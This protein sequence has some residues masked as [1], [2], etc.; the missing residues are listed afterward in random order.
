MDS[1]RRWLAVAALVGLTVL[2]Y[3]PSLRA[4]FIWDDDNFLTLNP[5][6][7]ASDGLY[8]FWFTTQATDYW[9]VTSSTLWVEWRLWGMHA[10][11][12]HATNLALHVAE[13]LLLW[14]VLRRLRLPGATLAALLFAVH[15]VN[16]ESVAWIAQRKNLVAMLFFL[17]SVLW[18]L[19]SRWYEVGRV[20]PN[21]PGLAPK[22]DGAQGGLGTSR[23]AS[24]AFYWLSLAAFALA[25]LGKG[26]VAPLPVV[27]LGLIAW[28]RPLTLGDAWRAAPFFV[29]AGVLA[30][31]NV[32]FQ[33]HGSG[34]VIRPVSGLDRLLG[35]AGIVWFYLWKAVVPTRLLFIYPQWQI[36]A[37]ALGWW[38]PL[39][40]AAALTTILWRKS[41][42]AFYAW[43]YFCVMLV[44]VL[45]FTDTAFMEYTPVAN[46][47]AHLALIGVVGLA[48]T[49][50]A[51][52]ERTQRASAFA[53]AAIVI[54]ILGGL[55]FRQ[56]QIYQNVE[57]LYRTTLEDNPGSWVAHG[58]LGGLLAGS[59]R[60]PEAI[61][62]FTE[63]LRLRPDYPQARVGLGSALASLGRLDEARAQFEEALRLR[64]DFADAHYNLGLILRATG[65][66]PEAA[67]QFT[68]AL[69]LKP[70]FPEAHN[71]LGVILGE[72]GRKAEA[73]AHFEAALELNPDYAEARTNLQIAQRMR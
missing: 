18:F 15:P 53:A 17:L 59:G 55:T 20:V 42:P 41:R 62:H 52:W 23:P 50:W 16:V 25:M 9:P 49:G 8:R 48:A 43:G 35:A 33:T 47:Y 10:A 58:N 70:S 11:G 14:E 4:G 66:I 26:S 61:P 6:I 38:L 21:P 72:A 57:T 12:Y 63:A 13:V 60:L 45:G 56:N 31:V 22:N 65:H 68:E 7:K 44:P 51:R 5:L 64:P 67:A 37:H 32:W 73:I 40:A 19:R 69:R 46:H 24:D 39:L 28:R 36:S 2:A 34:V 1:R 3:L 29:V 54:A 27:L 71:N 30:A